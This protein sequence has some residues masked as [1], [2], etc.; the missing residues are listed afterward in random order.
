VNGYCGAEAT[1][2]SQLK[3]A[4]EIELLSEPTP[5]VQTLKFN[6]DRAVRMALGFKLFPT[7]YVAVEGSFF[8][9]APA[10][11]AKSS[12]VRMGIELFLP[13]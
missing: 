10:V 8:E 9:L 7:P 12:E 5:D 13:I 1:L 2:T 11:G 4:G 3:V 6:V